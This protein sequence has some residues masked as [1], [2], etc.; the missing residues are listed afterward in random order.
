MCPRM[1]SGCRG[2]SSSAKVLGL[3]SFFP[4]PGLLAD[5]EASL[6]DVEAG[7]NH[8]PCSGASTRLFQEA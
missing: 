6:V 4:F 8:W 5:P 2:G 3:P 1:E 7:S